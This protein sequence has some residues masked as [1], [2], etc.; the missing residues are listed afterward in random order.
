VQAAGRVEDHDVA[1]VGLRPLDPVVHGL[2]RV[3]ALA[4]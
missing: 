2:D 3:D 1:P 4:A